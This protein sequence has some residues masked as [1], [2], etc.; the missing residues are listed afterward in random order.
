MLEPATVD[1]RFFAMAHNSKA[2]MVRM[3]VTPKVTESAM[4]IVCELLDPE[5]LDGGPGIGAA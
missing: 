2:M 5:P 3:A 1:S 4:V